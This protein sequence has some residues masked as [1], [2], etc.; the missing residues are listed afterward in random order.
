METKTKEINGDLILTEDFKF[1]GNLIVHG[2]IRGKDGRKYYIE[3]SNIDAYDIDANNIR[4]YNIDANNIDVYNIVANDI[5]AYDI[6]AY[7]IQANDIEARD[8]VCERIKSVKRIFARSLIKNR[9][10][11]LRKDFNQEED[12]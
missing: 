3:A 11:I 6:D 8:I 2:N 10:T 12:K 9:S 1:D 7:N 4:A 5:D